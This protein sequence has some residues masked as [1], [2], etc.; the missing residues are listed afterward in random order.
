VAGY[1]LPSRGFM[2]GRGDPEL[3]AKVN[4]AARALMN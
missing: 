4:R 2:P 3:I 1:H